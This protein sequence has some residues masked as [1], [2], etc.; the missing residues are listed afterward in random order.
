VATAVIAWSSPSSSAAT[1]S[2]EDWAS[3]SACDFNSRFV[4]GEH[5]RHRAALLLHAGREDVFHVLQRGVAF[6]PCP[7]DRP[8][9]IRTS[10]PRYRCSAAAIRVFNAST[11]AW[12]FLEAACAGETTAASASVG[13]QSAAMRRD[14][15]VGHEH[16]KLSESP[17]EGIG[18][19]A[20]PQPI[21]CRETCGRHRGFPSDGRRTAMIGRH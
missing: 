2:S 9:P 17:G 4:G 3:L 12:S 7:T 19:R 20:A 1:S 13:E 21:P 11:A 18:A 15:E 10:A 5:R 14:S 8:L 16:I 6:P